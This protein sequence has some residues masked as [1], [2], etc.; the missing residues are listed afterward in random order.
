MNWNRPG[1]L[2]FFAIALAGTTVA[3]PAPMS[4]NL[5]FSVPS[6]ARAE[7]TAELAGDFILNCSGGTPTAAGVEVP[8]TNVQ[9]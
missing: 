4:C 3:Q 1:A 9:V 7:G 5:G 8:R 2:A 6:I